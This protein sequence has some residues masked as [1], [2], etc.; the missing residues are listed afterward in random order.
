[1]RTFPK[2]IFIVA[3]AVCVV[4]S[5]AFALFLQILEQK[6]LNI[7]GKEFAFSQASLSFSHDTL[8]LDLTN[9]ED[10]TQSVFIERY[11]HKCTLR[12]LLALQFL[13]GS[14]ITIKNL[15]ISSQKNPLDIF[16]KPQQGALDFPLGKI[17]ID[18]AAITFKDQPSLKLYNV[19]ISQNVSTI[20]KGFASFSGVSGHFYIK[21]GFRENL[22]R[23]SWTIPQNNP[24]LKSL[25][26]MKN[27]CNDE[28][29]TGK[30]IIKMHKNL[31]STKSSFVLSG[32]QKLVHL[33]SESGQPFK[34][35]I[36]H[37][38]L[39][40]INILTKDQVRRMTHYDAWSLESLSL[41]DVV[42]SIPLAQWKPDWDKTTVQARIHSGLVD[43][44]NIGHVENIAGIFKFSFKNGWFFDIQHAETKSGFVL[45][46]SLDPCSAQFDLTAP[47]Q[48]AIDVFTRLN[49]LD[50]TLITQTTG[51]STGTLMFPTII[52][53][54]WKNR[55]S[56]SFFTTNSACTVNL[57]ALPKPI[58]AT[59]AS[60]HVAFK[61]ALCTVDGTFISENSPVKIHLFQTRDS[62]TNLSDL[63]IDLS[64]DHTVFNTMKSFFPFLSP[65]RKG[66]GPTS[67]H[68]C[69]QSRQNKPHSIHV[70]ANGYGFSPF[71]Y[72]VS[73]LRKPLIIDQWVVNALFEDDVWFL[74]NI[75]LKGPSI[76]ITLSGTARGNRSTFHIA[77][78]RYETLRNIEGSWSQVP[79]TEKSTFSL[80][81]P[82]VHIN[83]VQL[84]A[85][86]STQNTS[87]TAHV[88]I[89]KFFSTNTHF[90][91]DMR[92]N[93][94]AE[95]DGSANLSAYTGKDKTTSPFVLNTSWN[96]GEMVSCVVEGTSFSD[97]LR[98][99]GITTESISVGPFTLTFSTQAGN[100]TIVLDAKNIS[101]VLPS[102]KQSL[103]AFIL[104]SGRSKSLNF[105][106]GE[107]KGI[108]NN[109]I[110][111][112]EKATLNSD[113]LS[114]FVHEGTVDCLKGKLLLSGNI[115]PFKTVKRGAAILT[116]A[117]AKVFQ[118][119]CALQSPLAWHFSIN[120][121]F[122][123]LRLL[124]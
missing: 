96:K 113:D 42:V 106:E 39:S 57:S 75:T 22:V 121:D 87:I 80:N 23:L 93:F 58:V 64:I 16:T 38:S 78:S 82:S 18:K 41:E 68:I 70:T 109:N 63:T 99:A 119:N 44:R 114:V 54:D 29:L 118:G 33:S 36:K 122:P 79:S 111:T 124:V 62:Q 37:L 92:A 97:L 77:P 81:L 3:W 34:A 20:C 110:L 6:S 59:K 2:I 91:E 17:V 31:L 117:L 13:E 56:G 100:K 11:I 35:H 21:H 60:L 102:Q 32:I 12:S 24:F 103:F 4:S 67:M 9:V 108:L 66:H 90:L 65:L 28:P 112:L 85:L 26:I 83:D 86:Q 7:M 115:S 45:K 51:S 53:P 25:D 5:G 98:F 116:P 55:V 50:K 19:A 120:E 95:K 43:L 105:Q 73:T 8:S 72:W 89:A 30:T 1:M 49:I 107:L 88:N 101:L 74:R 14:F 40:D 94:H 76:D 27:A 123:P 47:S 52:T 46:G 71:I 48:A 69:R 10:K 61:N 104:S 15:R 84:L